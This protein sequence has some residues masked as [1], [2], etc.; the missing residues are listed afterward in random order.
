MLKQKH[1]EL[2]KV[3]NKL[4]FSNIIFNMKYPISQKEKLS[5]IQNSSYCLD[6]AQISK[7]ENVTNPTGIK[8]GRVLTETHI[9]FHSQ[10]E[11]TAMLNNM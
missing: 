3:M 1:R 9:L 10:S 6:R 4:P 8:S 2:C 7:E 5:V 11:N